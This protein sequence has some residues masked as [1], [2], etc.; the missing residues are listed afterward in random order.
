MENSLDLV[1][2]GVNLEL[3]YL[4]EYDKLLISILDFN[5]YAVA[6]LKR[7]QIELL[8]DYLI[9]ITENERANNT[10]RAI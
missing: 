7:T 9:K 8:R 3:E 10:I 1:C 2:Y 6:D 4:Q 5:G